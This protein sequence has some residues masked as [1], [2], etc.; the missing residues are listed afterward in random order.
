MNFLENYNY[1]KTDAFFDEETRAEL[2]ALDIN[3]DKEEI[4]DKFYKNLEFGTAGLRGI[5]MTGTNGVNKYTIAK[6]STG[7]ARYLLDNYSANDCQ[8]KGV[9]IAYDT[10]NNSEFFANITANVFSSNG[11]KVYLYKRTAPIPVL[12]YGVRKFGA[13]AGIVITA[14]HNPRE[15][16]GYK[17][18][19]N[20]GCQI[21]PEMAKGVAAK[22]DEI[23]DYSVINFNR[24]NALVEDV[25]IIDDYVSE[26]M[27][28]S[29]IKDSDT[30]ANLKIVYTPIHG[31]GYVPVTKVLEA[32]GFTDVNIVKEQ[33]LPDGNFPTVSAPNPEK[34]DALELG[35]KLAK[36][37]DA[38]VVLGTDADADRV[39]IAVKTS[40]GY[41]LITGNQIGALIID[42]LVHKIDRKI[43]PKPI[44]VNTVVTSELG[45]EIAKK[46][47]VLMISVLIG[48]KFIGEKMNLFEKAK[49]EKNQNFNYD[50]IF[51]YEESYGY[52]IGSHARDK[53]AVVAT[54]L[55]CEIAAEMKARGITFIDRLNELYEEYGYYIDDQDSVWFK[56]GKEGA[57]K[58]IEIMRMLRENESPFKNTKNVVDY[59]NPVIE[60]EGFEKLPA[61]NILKFILDDGSWVAI[62]PSGNEPKIKIYYSSKASTRAEAEEKL[63]S[64]KAT[65][66]SKLN[67]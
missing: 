33:A 22:I 42:Y 14:S 27:S 35:I 20:T 34:K 25:D 59:I 52:L 60:N 29:R 4:Q 12:S 17:V 58:I 6:A 9:V 51:G 39:G 54:M 38:D 30:K 26:I 1:W 61:S 53:D 11:V 62:R 41:K 32:D 5:M 28:Q 7:L 3:K 8:T 55:L 50:F 36:E 65:I 57:E 47:D 10:R 43:T 21:T 23:T 37:I 67:V 40:D 2:E 13:L 56:E 24:N 16:N 18:Y 44:I 64:L 15:Y 48:F 31:S 63:E 46:H 19:D 45:E 49:K 66:K